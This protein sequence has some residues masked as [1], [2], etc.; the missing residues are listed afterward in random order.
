M[1]CTSKIKFFLGAGASLFWE[2]SVGKICEHLRWLMNLLSLSG[3]IVHSSSALT[4]DIP[5]I[6]FWML[7][8][9]CERIPEKLT[10]LVIQ[11]GGLYVQNQVL[12]HIYSVLLR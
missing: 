5:G 2:E 4:S 7:F 12:I 11:D 3:S 10:L 9:F 6:C 8:L 1:S